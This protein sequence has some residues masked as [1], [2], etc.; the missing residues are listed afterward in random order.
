MIVNTTTES[1]L[2]STE[3]T[4][5]SRQY[6]S[7][8]NPCLWLQKVIFGTTAKKKYRQ[9]DSHELESN[10]S[11]FVVDDNIFVL[12]EAQMHNR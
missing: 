1:F 11:V 5:L 6:D 7:Q 9:S 3:C 12:A 10:L 8:V 2:R 4:V